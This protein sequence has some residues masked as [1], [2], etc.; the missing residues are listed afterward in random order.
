MYDVQV[1]ENDTLLPV[2]IVVVVVA[3]K[4]GTAVKLALTT[5]LTGLE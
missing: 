3:D 5:T 1:A 2:Q 4:V